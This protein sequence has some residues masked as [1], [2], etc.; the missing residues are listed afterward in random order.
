MTDTSLEQPLRKK[1]SSLYGWVTAIIMVAIMAWMYLSPPAF[2]LDNTSDRVSCRP[3]GPGIPTPVS[4]LSNYENTVDRY[5]KSAGMANPSADDQRDAL[6]AL[7]QACEDARL[8]RQTSLLI[9][10]SITLASALALLIARTKRRV[11]SEQATAG[12]PQEN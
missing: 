3:L 4:I 7:D 9:T 11:E 8:N 10:L 2:Y 6:A 12:I 5:L 1:H